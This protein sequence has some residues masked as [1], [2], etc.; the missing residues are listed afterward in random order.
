MKKELQLEQL[1]E[2]KGWKAVGNKFPI[3]SIVKI[4]QLNKPKEEVMDEA[5]LDALKKSVEEEVDKEDK[6]Q[7]G[8]FD[9]G[10]PTDK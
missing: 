6:D 7:L 2:V 3:Q 5:T 4:E 1:I 8:L 9:G 10:A